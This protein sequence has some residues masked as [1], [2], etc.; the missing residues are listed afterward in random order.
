MDFLCVNCTSTAPSPTK[1]LS[2][3]AHAV[4]SHRLNAP[5]QAPTSFKYRLRIRRGKRPLQF[6]VSNVASSAIEKRRSLGSGS[7][8]RLGPSNKPSAAMEQL[9]FERGV[10]V[11]FRKYTPEN[12]RNSTLV[13]WI[14]II[15]YSFLLIF[16]VK[17]YVNV[18]DNESWIWRDANDS[19]LVGNCNWFSLLCF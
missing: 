18:V 16:V 15:F 5:L 13:H 10:C 3:R 6:R 19:V 1:H 17:L 14:Y 9:D 8:S 4:P 2:S 12:V 7:E 11:P